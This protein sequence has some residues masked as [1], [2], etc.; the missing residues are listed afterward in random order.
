MNKAVKNS[1]LVIDDEVANIMAFT[2]I[3]SPDYNIH[4]QKNGKFAVQSAEKLLPDIIL[5]DIIMPE[6][7]GYAVLAE[8][9]ASPVA[10]DIPVIFITGLSGDA[11]EEKGLALGAADYISKP[12]SPAIVKHRVGNQIKM[13]EKRLEAEIANKTKSVFLANM[14]HEI[15]TPMNA[16]LGITEI[17]MQNSDLQPQI[18]EGLSKIHSSCDLLLGIINDILDFS[19]IEAGKLDIIPDKYDVAS[20]INNSIQL[21]MMKNDGKPIEFELEIDENIPVKLVGDELRIKQILN[22]LLSNAFKYTDEGKITL[23]AAFEAKGKKK[24]TLVL[25]VRDTGHGMTQEQIGGLFQEYTRFY[26]NIQGTGL[27]L[28]ITQ[29]LINLMNGSI[30]VESKPDAGSLF[31][32]RLPQEKVNSEV[33]GAA[34]SSLREFRSEGVKSSKKAQIVCEPMPYGRVLIV[35]DVETNLYVA[36]GLMRPYGLQIETCMSGRAAIEKINGGNK[37]DIIF[38]DHMMPEID[39]IETTKRLRASGYT[40][41]IAVLTANAVAGQVNMFMQNGFDAFISKPIDIRQLN[42][43]LNK[44]IRD[45]QPPEVL[46]AAREK[47]VV[48]E[49]N[50]GQSPLLL[51]SFIRDAKKSAEILRVF[52]GAKDLQDFVVSIHGIKSSLANI[53]EKVLCEEAFSL[54]KHGRAK[55]IDA[56]TPAIEP[57]LKKL[58]ALIEKL[59]VQQE[60]QNADGTDEN[61]EDLQNK[62]LAI[63]KL[64]GDYNRKGSLEMLDGIKNCSARTREILDSIRELVLCSKFDEAESAAA[65]FAADLSLALRLQNTK[66]DGLDMLKGVERYG[67]DHK[68]YLKVLRSFTTNIASMLASTE[69]IDKNTLVDYEIKI[70]GIK[71]AS[72]DIFAEKIAEEARTLE[73]AAKDGDLE[74][75]SKNDKIF[76]KKM[77][78]FIGDIEAMISIIDA[79]NPKPKKDKPDTEVLTKLLTACK[80]Y[81]MDGAD[82]AVAEIEKYQ[83]TA[84][85][86]LSDWLCERVGLMDFRQIIEKLSDISPS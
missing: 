82:E 42:S 73:H 69:N 71:G 22:N 76:R 29:R 54:E 16:I 61:I 23:S 84:D 1:I 38:M 30:S 3:L 6:M 46:E 50:G 52:D 47:I 55:N 48:S 27:G 10:R 49:T 63:K 20:L 60:A 86:G 80:A 77:Q 40:A 41:P 45:K 2:E 43:V 56:L 34:A 57:F 68:L 9:K 70:H 39:G 75:I 37:Y 33:L 11:D 72:F 4:V 53:G 21:N 62:L 44:F 78:K 26:R 12:F 79:E 31:V 59:E 32:V 19:K 35:D 85:N 24:G 28:T 64:C 66:I 74:Y 7:D 15:R 17:M 67:G 18:E 83:Y 51:K 25:S 13:L 58:L 65:C 36:A 14:S 8:L 5:L 81:S